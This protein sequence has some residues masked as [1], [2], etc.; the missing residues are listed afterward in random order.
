MNLATHNWQTVSTEELT[1]LG[2]TAAQT[3][4]TSGMSLTDAVV[5]SIGMTK[6]NAEQ[7]RRVV[8]A[9]NHE[10]FH[11]KFASMDPSM[12]VVELDG[13]PADPS[14]VIERLK[15][16]S[17]PVRVN[18]RT[19]DY[20]SPPTAKVASFMGLGLHKHS[21]EPAEK[22]AAVAEVYDLREK[23]QASHEEV[24][25]QVTASKGLITDDVQKLAQL[26]RGA[27]L[28]G[29]YFEDF[30]AAWGAVSP[31]HATELLSVMRPD[32]APAGVKTA[33][34]RIS[35]GHPLRSTFAAFV[36]HAQEYEVACKALRDVELEI[37]RVDDFLRSTR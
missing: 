30:E 23:L 24:A 34:R 17:A 3:A 27:A 20:A 25:S 6:L 36:K 35:D 4:E 16:A 22:R 8:E 37:V 32:R 7:I 9:A 14:A 13:G 11:R 31:K 28:D 19:S 26:V 12:R 21:F 29:A 10:A 2:K 33:S 1:H 18:G 15:A 5:R